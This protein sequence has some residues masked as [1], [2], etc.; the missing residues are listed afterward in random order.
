ML[1]RI[2]GGIQKLRNMADVGCHVGQTVLMVGWG[3]SNGMNAICAWELESSFMEFL[4]GCES[5]A[6]NSNKKVA[7]LGCSSLLRIVAPVM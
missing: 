2:Q 5:D 6:N 4:F 1:V 3:G 7:L